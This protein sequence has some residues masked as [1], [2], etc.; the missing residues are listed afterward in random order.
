MDFSQSIRRRAAAVRQ[1]SLRELPG[2]VVAASLLAVAVV[3]LAR[4]GFRPTVRRMQRLWPERPAR[5]QDGSRGIAAQRLSRIVDVA[6]VFVPA[7]W[8]TCLTRSLVLSTMLR[9]VGIPSEVRIG[10]RREGEG[11]HAHAWADADGAPVNESC[12][13]VRGY[14][15]FEGDVTDAILAAVR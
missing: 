2:L 7:G 5:D 3:G 15:V 13:V 11:L 10:I 6:A 14:L 9:H 12:D 1:L 8:T 4:W